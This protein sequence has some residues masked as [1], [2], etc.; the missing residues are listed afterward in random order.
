MYFHHGRITTIRV[1]F[2]VLANEQEINAIFQYGIRAQI[3]ARNI[4]C[5]SSKEP[6]CFEN[7]HDR[8]L[9]RNRAPFH[10]TCVFILDWALWTWPMLVSAANRLKL[11]ETSPACLEMEF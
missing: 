3:I 4:Y 9:L 6:T 11:P 2:F 5:A 10:C 7:K 8:Q 1:L